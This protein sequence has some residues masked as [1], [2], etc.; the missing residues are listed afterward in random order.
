[1]RH[2]CDVN[3]TLYVISALPELD[4]NFVSGFLLLLVDLKECCLC[5]LTVTLELVN[6]SANEVIPGENSL[7]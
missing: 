4:G 3:H 5:L 2:D 1:M 6:T 7:T